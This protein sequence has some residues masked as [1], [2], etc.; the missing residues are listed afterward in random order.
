MPSVLDV[1]IKQDAVR[2][3]DRYGTLTLDRRHLIMSEV[4]TPYQPG[5]CCQVTDDRARSR[6]ESLTHRRTSPM[7]NPTTTSVRRLGFQPPHRQ[8]VVAAAKG[9]GLGQRRH[10]LAAA[11]GLAGN[12]F[13]LRRL[14]P[15]MPIADGRGTIRDLARSVRWCQASTAQNSAQKTPSSKL[16]SGPASNTTW[17]STSTYSP[18]SSSYCQVI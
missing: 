11:A 7:K 10:L 2:C 17:K 18:S 15:R 14:A 1:L 6:D 16:L 9:T 8:P 13:T 12:H 4:Q 3:G 5:G